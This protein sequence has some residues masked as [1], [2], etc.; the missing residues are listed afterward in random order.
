MILFIP[1]SLFYLQIHYFQARSHSEISG[2]YEFWKMLFY[3]LHLYGKIIN[4][5]LFTVQLLQSTLLENFIIFI[6][7][8]YFKTSMLMSRQVLQLKC[9][10][11]LFQNILSIQENKLAFALFVHGLSFPLLGFNLFQDLGNGL[12]INVVSRIWVKCRGSIRIIKR[13]M[14]SKNRLSLN[15]SSLLTRYGNLGKL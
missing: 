3:Q 12:F 7:Y 6:I 5:I 14:E 4:Y 15:L 10:I 11:S 1:L 8:G 13:Y 2:G 9:S